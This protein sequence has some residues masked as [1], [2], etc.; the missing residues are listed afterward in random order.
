[1]PRGI[2]QPGSGRPRLSAEEEQGRD[3]A[4]RRWV[5]R[6]HQA[7]VEARA[8][9][10]AARASEADPVPPPDADLDEFEQGWWVRLAARVDLAGTFRTQDHEAFRLLVLSV[11]DVERS[12]GTASL[13]S[14]TAARRAVSA[15]LIRWGLD[16]SS[17]GD[18]RTAKR[19]ATEIEALSQSPADR[20]RL[21][22]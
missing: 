21:L 10:A 2:R 18:A 16:P 1:V 14:L 13:S 12:R 20:L 22:K 19:I 17:R 8:D 3:P 4:V 7:N 5:E 9:A 11:C 15:L 6:R